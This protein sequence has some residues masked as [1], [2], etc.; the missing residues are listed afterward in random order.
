MYPFNIALLVSTPELWEE[1]QAALQN[2]PVR[3]VFE[4]SALES[5]AVLVDKVER[6]RPEILLLDAASQEGRL[7]ELVGS[8]RTSASAP[9][10]VVVDRSSDPQRI[11]AAM[12]AGANEY[13]YPPLTSTLKEAFERLSSDHDPHVRRAVETQKGRIIGFLSAKG[14]CGATTLACHTALEIQSLTG[15]E[16]VLADLDLGSGLV[17]F[18][19]QAK[20]RYS[21]VDAMRNVARLDRSY[22]DGLVSNGR[23]GL[24]VLSAPL[25]ESTRDLPQLHEIRHVLRFVR[26]HYSWLIAD[27]G[28]GLNAMAWQAAEELDELVLVSTTEV[29]A[30]H[31]AKTIAHQLRDAG[32]DSDRLR[33]VLNRVPRKS[34]VTTEELEQALGLKVFDTVPNDYR[35]LEQAYAEGRLLSSDHVVRQ[36][37]GRIAGK[38]AGRP[39]QQESRRRGRFGIFG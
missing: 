20:T 4:M 9:R 17:R 5:T 16:T 38:L 25:E 14:G 2:L 3:I 26:S 23:P 37:I 34:E 15:K 24:E 35:A 28:H 1:V 21:V 6:Y 29:P 31:R 7:P 30:L 22:W 13:L 27:L 8:V 12:R 39:P 10:V 32:F 11:L 18:L 36:R 33:L 19:M